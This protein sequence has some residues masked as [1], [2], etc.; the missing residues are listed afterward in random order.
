MNDN[1]EINLAYSSY[2]ITSIIK[3][4]E[5]GIATITRGESLNISVK[6]IKGTFFKVGLPL[7][8]EVVQ[9]KGVKWFRL[10]LMRVFFLWFFSPPLFTICLYALTSKMEVKAIPHEEGGIMIQ[11]R[12]VQT[13]TIEHG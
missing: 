10:K 1:P 4:L 7:L 8:Q 6:G 13:N 9:N 5:M 3:F 2:P 12:S 11:I